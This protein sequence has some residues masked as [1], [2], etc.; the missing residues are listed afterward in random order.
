M[1]YKQQNNSIYVDYSANY[2]VPFGGDF[3]EF[4]LIGWE[5][6]SFEIGRKTKLLKI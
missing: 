3:I 2:Y 5:I 4:W 6:W 1:N